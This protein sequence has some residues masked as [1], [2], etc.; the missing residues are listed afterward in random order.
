MQ[1]RSASRPQHAGALTVALV[2]ALAALPPTSLAQSSGGIYEITRFSVHAG[3]RTSSG[4]VYTLVGSPG[5]AEAAPVSALAT[6]Y[7]LTGGWLARGARLPPAGEL[8]SNGFE[9]STP[10]ITGALP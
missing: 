1:C 5:Q 7:S 4:D 6:G 2:L 10:V 9:S 8:F 3:G